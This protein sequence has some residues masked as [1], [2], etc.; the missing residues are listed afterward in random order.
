[1][2]NTNNNFFTL[3]CVIIVFLFQNSSASKQENPENVMWTWKNTSFY[4]FQGIRYA[5]PPIGP[6]R[7]KVSATKIVVNPF[8]HCVT[9]QSPEPYYSNWNVADPWHLQT[10]KTASPCP[11]PYTS[12]HNEDCLH[13]NVYTRNLHDRR[14]VIVL[15][16]PGGFYIGSGNADHFGP[17]Y[18]L[19]Q[20]VV[21]VTFNYRLGFLGFAS[22]GDS[23]APGNAGLKDQ[24]L[25]MR[26]VRQNIAKFG[27]DADLVTI[28]G[29]SAGAMSVVLHLVSPMSTGLFHRA[30][31]L[32]GSLPP[33]MRLPRNQMELIHRQVVKM[34]CA[35]SDWFGCLM[36]KNA[37]VLASNVYKMF[38]FVRDNPIFLW[39]PV[40][41]EAGSKGAFLTVDDPL[42]VI[43]IGDFE[44]VPLLVGTTENELAS[45]AF[46]LLT[47]AT[48]RIEW[49]QDFKRWGPVCLLYERNTKHSHM[50]SSEVWSYYFGSRC[51][52]FEATNNVRAWN[53]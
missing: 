33:Q 26:W 23:R 39:L 43:A 22:T 14:P 35:S 51:C 31:V 46:E 4:G 42:E 12:D 38:E 15:I 10:N 18:L 41:E 28:V 13:L 20:P 19:E 21:L 7:F 2:N 16:H 50:I 3:L 24:A 47:N 34:N 32:S 17:E 45:S 9:L 53:L 37:S 30:V 5:E 27:G 49:E 52:T 11:S 40:V 1:M 25:A 48:G 44:K 36:A 6:L 29:A 8:V